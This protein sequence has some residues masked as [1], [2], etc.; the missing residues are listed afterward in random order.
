MVEILVAKIQKV[1]KSL[2]PDFSKKIALWKQKRMHKSVSGYLKIP[3]DVTENW[4]YYHLVMY[5]EELFAWTN[6]NKVWEPSK[7]IH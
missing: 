5:G 7:T 1:P 2:F 6:E 3:M 4:L